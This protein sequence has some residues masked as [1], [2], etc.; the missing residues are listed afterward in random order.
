VG[1][2]G[3]KFDGDLSNGTIASHRA[4]DRWTVSFRPNP[5]GSR[6]RVHSDP[7][8]VARVIITREHETA[9]SVPARDTA[10]AKLRDTT[11]TQMR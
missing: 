2:H 10:A 5:D 7:Y 11:E 1:P 6:R 4:E 3:I 9:T 8:A